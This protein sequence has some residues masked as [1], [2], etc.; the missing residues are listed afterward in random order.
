MAFLQKHKRGGYYVSCVG[1]DERR[2]RIYF[3]QLSSKQAKDILAFVSDLERSA[4]LALDAKP[5]T[6][7]WTKNVS[8]EIRAKLQAAC[9]MVGS[10]PKEWLLSEWCQ[11][12]IDDNQGSVGTVRKMKSVRTSLLAM[13]EDKHLSEVTTGDCRRALES[14]NSSL[15][16]TSANKLATVSKMFFR[17]AIEDKLIESNPFDGLKFAANKID[18]E[19]ESYIDPDKFQKII[20]K[21][22]H[23]QAELLFRLA[24]FGGLRIP[25]EALSLEWSHCDWEKMQLTIPRGTKTGYRVMPIFPGFAKQLQEAFESAEDGS[26]YVITERR[27]SARIVWRKWLEEAISKAGQEVWPKLWMNL[28]ASCRTDL[29]EKF[30]SHVCDVWLGHSTK[31][32]KEH[33]LR[34]TPDHWKEAIEV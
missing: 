33:Y 19:R 7:D 31:V 34:V 27:Q 14:W 25:H 5:T 16:P 30:P 32:A 21:A 22:C 10:R 28:R 2:H 17:F 11:K 15:A 9:L 29:E 4:R 3:G 24:R 12:C 6:V 1:L 18:K 13:I 8:N 23:S 26:I 20:D